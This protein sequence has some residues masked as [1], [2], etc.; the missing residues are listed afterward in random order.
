MVPDHVPD[1]V[2]DTDWGHRGRAHAVGH[3][4]GLVRCAYSRSD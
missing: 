1:V 2:G 3:L 4:K